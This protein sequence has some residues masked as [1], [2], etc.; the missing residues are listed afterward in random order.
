MR[1]RAQQLGG[2]LS[3]EDDGGTHLQASL[4]LPARTE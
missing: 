3:I 4:P 1:A 2:T